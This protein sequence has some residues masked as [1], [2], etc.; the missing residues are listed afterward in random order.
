MVLIAFE[1]LSIAETA[2]LL[3]IT[4]QNV[5]ATLSAARARLKSRL[6]PY[7]GFAEK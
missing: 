1:G 2:V 3:E 7:L 6:A 5:H 4:E